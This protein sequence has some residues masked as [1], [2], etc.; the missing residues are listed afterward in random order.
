[1][2][3]APNSV[4]PGKAVDI[5][6]KA[7]PNSYVGVLGVDQSVLLLRTGNDITRVNC[8]FLSTSIFS[9]PLI[10]EKIKP[11]DRIIFLPLTGGCLERSEN[12]RWRSPSG[13]YNMV[14]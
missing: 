12:L 13:L 8:R 10:E 2:E 7:E 11:I 6:V 3:V 1:M 14:P 4:E 9:P 5:T